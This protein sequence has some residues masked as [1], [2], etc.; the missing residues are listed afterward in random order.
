MGIPAAELGAGGS[1]D[2]V[3]QP[4][5]VIDPG[6]GAHQVE[7]GPGVLDEVVGQ[8]DGGGEG[9]GTDGLAPAVPE[10]AGQVQ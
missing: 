7:D 8:P 3:Q 1:A 2:P 9:A 5:G 4:A 6:V 10:V